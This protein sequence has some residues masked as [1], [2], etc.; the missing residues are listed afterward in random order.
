MSSSGIFSKGP[1][2]TTPALLI[3]KSKAPHLFSIALVNSRMSSIREISPAKTRKFPLGNSLSSAFSLSEF[4]P[5]T[6]KS[7]A[8]CLYSS[9]I[10]ALPIP[11]PPLR[12]LA[13]PPTASSFHARLKIR[14]DNSLALLK[15]ESILK[16]IIFYEYWKFNYS[17]VGVFNLRHTAIGVERGL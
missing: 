13:S 10:S 5:I 4:L 6:A 17:I 2:L 1:A 8:P 7:L 3:S 9:P 15:I 12:L 14:Y 16:K 11:L